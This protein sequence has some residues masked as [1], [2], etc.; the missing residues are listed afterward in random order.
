MT[1]ALINA[2]HIEGAGPAAALCAAALAQMRGRLGFTVSADLSRAEGHQPPVILGP[3]SQKLLSAL[4]LNERDL[5]KACAGTFAV[6]A[7]FEG[8]NA[9]PF[10]TSAPVTNGVALHQIHGAGKPG[11]PYSQYFTPAHMTEPGLFAHPDISDDYRYSVILDAGLFEHYMHRAAA[12]Y[13]C[14]QAPAASADLTVKAGLNS[15]MQTAQTPDETMPVSLS[16]NLSE[17]GVTATAVTQ[18]HKYVT[19][20]KVPAA[21]KQADM[22]SGDVIDAGSWTGE[23]HALDHSYMDALAF[24]LQSLFDIWPAS[25]DKALARSEFNRR[26]GSF[27]ARAADYQAAPMILA[28]YRAQ[29][30]ASPELTVKLTQFLSRG[31][32]VSFDDE[33]VSDAEWTAY[34]LAAGAKPGRTDPLASQFSAAQIEDILSGR[35]QAAKKR[36]A[37]MRSQTDYLRASDALTGNVQ[38]AAS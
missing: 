19:L 36:A 13:G 20:A 26:T 10:I 5:I 1:S 29:H 34:M 37:D 14:K 15:D 12:H 38:R 31:R 27:I 16:Y 4:G 28:G 25:A 24:S 9:C 23:L 2:V 32:L 8:G 3:Q 18:T 21:Q 17:T 6:S 22:W 11:Q 7:T 33:P 35:K 30:A